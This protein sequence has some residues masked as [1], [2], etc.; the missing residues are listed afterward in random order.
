MAQ[1]EVCGY[2][3]GWFVDVPRNRRRRTPAFVGCGLMGPDE[4]WLSLFRS[5]EEVIDG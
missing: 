1:P 2:H 3:V 5:I 4:D